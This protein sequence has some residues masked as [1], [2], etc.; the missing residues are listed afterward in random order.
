MSL[1]LELLSVQLGLTSVTGLLFSRSQG[2]IYGNRSEAFEWDK[3]TSL[4]LAIQQSGWNPVG[5]NVKQ[6][7]PI[8]LQRPP[9]SLMKTNVRAESGNIHP[10]G[11]PLSHYFLVAAVSRL[12]PVY[13][14][15]SLARG[16]Y[17]TS[18]VTVQ[19]CSRGF[20]RSCWRSG[21]HF[22]DT[23]FTWIFG[24]CENNM[25]SWYIG[26]QKL[27]WSNQTEV[28][29]RGQIFRLSPSSFLEKIPGFSFL[30]T[31]KCEGFFFLF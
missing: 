6:M 16:L 14:Q 15:V 18:D 24:Y 20:T 17:T 9:G 19:L 4:S 27:C 13:S 29:K 12:D 11:F 26:W 10:A 31:V 25:R 5:L 30:L 28:E 22:L 23:V 1:G 3:R 2:T 7:C 8:N 21:S